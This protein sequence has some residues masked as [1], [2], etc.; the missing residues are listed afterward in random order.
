V[1]GVFDSKETTRE[2]LWETMS[3]KGIAR[4]PFP[5]KGRIPN[6]VGAEKAAENLLS[7]SIFSNVKTLKI[8]PDSPQ[9]PVR[10]MALRKGITLLVPTPRLT[11]DFMIFDPA[12]IREEDYRKAS[13]LSHFKTYSKSI[14]LWDIP[15]VDLVVVGCVAVTRTGSRC[16]KGHGYG[17]LEYGILQELGHPVAPVVTTVH[18]AQVVEGFPVDEHDLPLSLI[19][20]PEEVIE[21]V[22]RAPSSMGIDWSAL[23]DEDMVAMPVLQRL[24]EGKPHD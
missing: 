6:F 21:V 18:G 7:H 9:R 13:Q 11:D 14:S 4:H 5:A 19:A 16:G 20:T 24:K 17:D 22:T 8:N 15:P 12:E 2:S 10:E 3:Q 23:S 1:A